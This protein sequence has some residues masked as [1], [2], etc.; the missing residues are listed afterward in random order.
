MVLLLLNTNSSLVMAQLLNNEL[1]TSEREVYWL[2]PVGGDLSS[3]SVLLNGALLE[4]VGDRDLPQL[5]P[6][7]QP[8]SNSLSLPSLSFGFI[9]FKDTKI[10]ACTKT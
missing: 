2:S 3:D 8:A 1:I 5:V 7:A 9:V 4:L 10:L 6:E